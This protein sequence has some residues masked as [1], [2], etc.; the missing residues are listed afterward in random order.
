MPAMIC[1]VLVLL[2]QKGI[3][4]LEKV[5]RRVERMMRDT[6]R[7]NRLGLFSLEKR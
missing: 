2:S 5:Q 3:V 4:K 6:E 1:A 7:L